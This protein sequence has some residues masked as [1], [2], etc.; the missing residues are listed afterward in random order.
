MRAGVEGWRDLPGS[1]LREVHQLGIDRG[2]ERHRVLRIHLDADDAPDQLPLAE[3]LQCLEPGRHPLGVELQGW[4]VRLTKFPDAPEQQMQAQQQRA[5][6]GIAAGRLF[7]RMQGSLDKEEVSG[8]GQQPLV[9]KCLGECLAEGAATD[10]VSQSLEVGR[11]DPG[12]RQEGRVAGDGHGGLAGARMHQQAQEAPSV[13]QRCQD[14]ANIGS[15][16]FITH[17]FCANLVETPT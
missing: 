2:D 15:A 11:G 3:G 14:S 12:C 7:T 16:L 17:S 10:F 1:G 13:I 8:Q 6:D 9:W 4:P 5:A